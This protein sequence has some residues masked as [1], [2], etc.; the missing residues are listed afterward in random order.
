MTP[1]DTATTVAAVVGGAF[2]L[3]IAAGYVAYFLA[4]TITRAARRRTI[5]K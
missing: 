2:V 3:T 5:R 1:G 4:P